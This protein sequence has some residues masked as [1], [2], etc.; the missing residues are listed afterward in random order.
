MSKD[1][2][3]G[4]N[5]NYGNYDD[6]LK[7]LQNVSKELPKG[8]S[9]KKQGTHLYLQFIHPGVNKRLP[10]PCGVQLTFD[11][12]Y[13]AKRKAFKIKHALDTIQ[14][15]TEFWDWYNKEILDKNEIKNDITTYKEIFEKLSSKY[16]NNR[17]KNTG[18]KRSRDIPNDVNS[19]NR[20][21]TIVFNKFPSWDKQPKWEDIKQ[22]L[23]SFE[24]GTNSFKDAY[25]IL[26]QVCNLCPNN[27]TLLEQLADIDATQHEFR[28][29]QSI[30]LDQ[31]LEWHDRALSE[32]TD[33]RYL[34]IRRSWLWVASMCVVYGLRPSEIAAVLNLYQSYKKDNVVILALND[35]DNKDLLLVLDE[36]TYFGTTIKTGSRICRPMTTD[37]TLI[38]RL[39]IQSPHLPV[40]TPRSDNPK[41]ITEGFAALFGKNLKR[42][43]CPV[44]QAYAFRH[45]ANQLGEKSGIPQEIRA[46]SL[47]HSVAVNDSTYKKRSNLQTS[48][49]LLT[50]HTYETLP[51][52][53]AVSI[54]SQM[55][56]KL[57]D[58]VLIP[59]VARDL[60][61]AIYGV[62]KDRIKEMMSN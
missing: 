8:I 58:K 45:L 54:A 24:Q 16:W 29:K 61:S 17:N 62:S 32:C 57:S 47:G 3:I 36:K 10:K 26:K 1:N 51:L 34:S 37:K 35:P 55:L 52:E 27:E 60:L 41:T 11:G 59:V 15:A 5:G 33:T 39:N 9:F 4:G 21:Y 56:D 46:R 38:D 7:T 30:S 28:D 20:H 12:I 42:W 19:F 43:N 48:V 50:N 44:S 2:L 18:R 31:F 13:E 25:T 6:L 14:S 53:S 40:Y 23:F 22:V 49:D